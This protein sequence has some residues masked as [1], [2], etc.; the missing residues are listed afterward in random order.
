MDCEDETQ[1][2]FYRIQDGGHTWPDAPLNIGVTNR[3][4]NATEEI[5]SF[6]NQ[7]TN[8]LASSVQEIETPPN[9]L[10]IAPNPIKNTFVVDNIAADAQSIRIV[11]TR[12]QTV[13]TIIPNGQTSL[14]IDGNTW[15]VGMYFVVVNS[16]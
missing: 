8:D 5:W 3:D 2:I 10:S 14:S 7:H 1:V 6:F 4:F 13:E 9:T 16:P 11:N 15:A 12:G